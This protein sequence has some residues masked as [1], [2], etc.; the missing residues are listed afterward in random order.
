MINGLSLVYFA[1]SVIHEG[2]VHQR[3]LQCIQ[4][5]FFI[6]Q[7]LLIETSSRD[8]LNATMFTHQITRKMLFVSPSSTLQRDAHP[9]ASTDFVTIVH[10][11]VKFNGLSFV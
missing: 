1:T 3:P 8:A 2:S 11:R 7:N 6:T 4:R 9:R 10:R 5:L